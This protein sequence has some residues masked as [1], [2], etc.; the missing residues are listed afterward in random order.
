VFFRA[1]PDLI[2]KVR[3]VHHAIPQAIFKNWPGLYEAGGQG[4][5]G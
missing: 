4:Q 2:G 5:L 3:E 1:Y